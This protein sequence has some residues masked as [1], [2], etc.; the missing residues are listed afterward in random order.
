V[1]VR[2]E[3]RAIGVVLPEWKVPLADWQQTTTFRPE[4]LKWLQAIA[5]T[6]DKMHERGFVQA[7]YVGDPAGQRLRPD[8]RLRIIGTDPSAV[9]KAERDEINGLL[10][11]LKARGGDS[12]YNQEQHPNRNQRYEVERHVHLKRPRVPR[13]RQQYYAPSLA[14]P[15]NVA[16]R[17]FIEIKETWREVRESPTRHIPEMLGNIAGKMYGGVI[18]L[19]ISGSVL[20]IK[21][22]AALGKG[23]RNHWHDAR[24]W[25]EQRRQATTRLDS[26]LQEL[27]D[28]RTEIAERRLADQFPD[29]SLPPSRQLELVKGMT[30]KMLANL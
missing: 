11:K 17:A 21:G 9:S 28:M 10:H 24:S 23:A 14:R 3:L 29:S 4:I 8:R 25:W 12:R 26:I 19:I 20:A 6:Y 1:L 13:T 30:A 5:D 22:L 15:L 16:E 2:Q 18:D 7:D 27:H